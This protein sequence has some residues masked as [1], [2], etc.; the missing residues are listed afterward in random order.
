MRRVDLSIS[1][2]VNGPI[3]DALIRA[4]RYRRGYLTKADAC[5]LRKAYFK[6]ERGETSLEMEVE[7]LRSGSSPFF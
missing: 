3:G 4:Y 5:Y 6:I 1:N 7:R 2:S